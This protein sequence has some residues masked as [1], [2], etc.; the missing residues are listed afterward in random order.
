MIC[1]QCNTMNA[2]GVQ[3]CGNCGAPLGIMQPGPQTQQPQMRTGNSR[4]HL[5][6]SILAFLWYP[7]MLVLWMVVFVIAAGVSAGEALGGGG[8]TGSPWQIQKVITAASFGA[9]AIALLL[10]VVVRVGSLVVSI[11]AKIRHY[12]NATLTLVLSVL[13]LIGALFVDLFLVIF[14]ILG[15]TA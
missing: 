2:D 11:R 13:A 5:L 10:G 14:G 6:L 12:P 4:L 15:P 9:L 1:A 8:T 7:M 3:F